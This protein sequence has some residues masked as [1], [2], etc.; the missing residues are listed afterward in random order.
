MVCVN[1]PKWR[2]LPTFTI[3]A[4]LSVTMAI[5]FCKMFYSLLPNLLQYNVHCDFS[6]PAVAL[7][8]IERTLVQNQL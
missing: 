8:T 3:V 6:Y 4:A 5:I 1:H 7:W 2:F